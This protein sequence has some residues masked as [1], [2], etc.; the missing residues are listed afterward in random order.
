[1]RV[2]PGDVYKTFMRLLQVLSDLPELSIMTLTKQGI[3]CPHCPT[4]VA[5]FL[6]RMLIFGSYNIEEIRAKRVNPAVTGL[7]KAQLK[8]LAKTL[9]YHLL[10][11][12]FEEWPGVNIFKCLAVDLLHQLDIGAFGRYLWSALKALVKKR[13]MHPLS[14]KQRI[15]MTPAF[16]S[17]PLRSSAIMTR[18]KL[19]G[20]EW[21]CLYH[22]IVPHLIGLF[23]EKELNNCVLHL[24]SRFATVATLASSPTLTDLA[25]ELIRR[26]LDVFFEHLVPF[27]EDAGVD[28]PN[29]LM[30]HMMNHIPGSARRFGAPTAS[31]TKTTIELQHKVYATAPTKRTNSR[32]SLKILASLNIAA[33]DA[34]IAQFSYMRVYHPNLI[35]LDK[36]D[37]TLAPLDRALDGA[38]A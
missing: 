6:K 25:L 1:M 13:V 20:H 17:N 28:L 16:S 24:F 4:E 23:C 31:S 33:R 27:F 12:G 8:A 36:V 29:A 5:Q 2:A 30:F 34:L 19:A 22:V 3:V 26:Y 10:K 14:L 15:S 38:R 18:D 11:S 32:Q 21:R 37:L 35:S 7:S 9:G